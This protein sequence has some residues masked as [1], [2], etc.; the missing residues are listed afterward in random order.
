LAGKPRDG[1][2]TALM[3]ALKARGTVKAGVQADRYSS[4]QQL[5]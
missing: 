5:H 3:R 1:A 4:G 2:L